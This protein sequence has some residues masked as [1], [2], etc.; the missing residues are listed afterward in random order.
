L[1]R[2]ATYLPHEFE[3]EKTWFQFKTQGACVVPG[4][5]GFDVFLFS[6]LPTISFVHKCGGI[7]VCID[8]M[9][10]LEE[11]QEEARESKARTSRGLRKGSFKAVLKSREI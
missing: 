4:R 7:K 6:P 1:I 11:E 5:K 3:N 9:K 10:K 8:E 2:Q